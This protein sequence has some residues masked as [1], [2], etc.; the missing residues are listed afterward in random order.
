MDDCEAIAEIGARSYQEYEYFTIFFADPERRYRFGVELQRTGYKVAMK[1]DR[2]LIGEE[3]GQIV[4]AAELMAPGDRPQTNWDFVKAGLFKMLKAGG[5]KDTLDWLSMQEQMSK[6]CHRLT[7]PHWYINSLA[8]REE[9][10][11]QNYGSEMLQRCIIPYVAEHGGGL[12]T[13]ITNNEPNRF[14]Y[15]KNG[16]EEFSSDQYTFRGQRMGNYGFWMRVKGV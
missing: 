15:L 2:V 12:L 7:E 5:V 14:F 11:G 1:R 4:A 8:V 6:V 10:K 16:F 3:G 9:S 13:L